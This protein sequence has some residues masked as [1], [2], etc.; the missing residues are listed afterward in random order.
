M[1]DKNG[2]NGLEDCQGFRS[3]SPRVLGSQLQYI[4][5]AFRFRHAISRIR[6][7]NSEYRRP[8]T[9]Q[10]QRTP[11]MVQASLHFLCYST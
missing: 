2:A 11:E 6:E 10:D 8:A 7:Q 1:E 4:N 3:Y 9:D 5:K